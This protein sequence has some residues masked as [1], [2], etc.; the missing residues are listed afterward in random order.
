MK[1]SELI[2]KLYFRNPPEVVRV[3][4]TLLQK[5]SIH[6][7]IK[8]APLWRQ[9]PFFAK[10]HAA[11][12]RKWQPKEEAIQRVAKDVLMDIFGT[13]GDFGEQLFRMAHW[14][15]SQDWNYSSLTHEDEKKSDALSAMTVLTR[16]RYRETSPLLRLNLVEHLPFIS[17][18]AIP[19]VVKMPIISFQYYLDVHSSFAF[20]SIRK[21][22]HPLSTELISYLYETLYIQQK[23]AI[24][25]HEYLRLVGY[26]EG[27]K[28]DAM[29][30]NAEINAI[31]YADLV[32]AYLKSSIEK[33][34]ALLGLIYLRSDLD[35]KKT[36]KAKLSALKIGLPIELE[37]LY[38]FKFI[39]EFISSENLDQ[40]NT[41]RSGLFH[42][43]GISDL[44]PHNY[45]G[46]KAENLPLKKIFEIL[47]EQHVKNTGVLIST[48][49]LLTD[50][51][52]KRD[53]PG[54]SA[55]ELFKQIFVD[56]K[57]K[58]SEFRE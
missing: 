20:N 8:L 12:V 50:D 56:E 35:S 46:E 43:R 17:A 5:H 19:M 40:L 41:Y 31:M 21:S 26:T 38:Y 47:H 25:L 22:S 34:V 48:L 15:H 13:P 4:G 58:T 52:V 2:N 45:V 23:I 3:M 53:P 7:V 39:M 33:T 1:L 54:L 28:N 49:A 55:E 24:S 11:L 44:Q 27:Q 9:E 29:F 42:K 16:L 51:L 57:A 14:H 30:I 6:A 36:H 18:L 32:F 37:S 10:L